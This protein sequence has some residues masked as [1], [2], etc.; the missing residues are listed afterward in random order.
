MKD[1]LNGNLSCDTTELDLL[2]TKLACILSLNDTSLYNVTP[3]QQGAFI[4]LTVLNMTS[5]EDAAFLYCAGINYALSAI[6]DTID[7]LSASIINGSDVNL[8]YAFIS[9]VGP[10]TSCNVTDLNGTFFALQSNI[11]CYLDLDQTYTLGWNASSA[12]YNVSAL[13]DLAKMNSA[14]NDCVSL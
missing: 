11:S 8:W 13:N 2:Q 5:Y 4:N 3:H 6:N 9:C 1:C 7:Y 10:N 14:A 12:L